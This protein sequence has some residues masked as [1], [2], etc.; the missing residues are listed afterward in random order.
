M[1]ITRWLGRAQVRA[2][3][4]TVTLSGTIVANDSFTV[5]IGGQAPVVILATNTVA[6]DVLT[7]VYNALIASR[8][9]EV[10]E[11]TWTAPS[12]GSMTYTGPT[13][14][15]AP[16]TITVATSGAATFATATTTS[17]TGPN[18]FDNT[19]NWSGAAVPTPGTDT[20]VFSNN[21][22]GMLYNISQTSTS[23]GYTVQ[24]DASTCTSQIGLSENNNSGYKE[25]RN[26]YLT[27]TGGTLT[28]IGGAN[29]GPN[30]INVDFNAT[31]AT[32]SI[33]STGQGIQR[34][35]VRVRNMANTSTLTMVSGSL[36][37]GSNASDGNSFFASA[38]ISGGTI[39]FGPKGC[40][41]DSLTQTGGTITYDGRNINS[42]VFCGTSFSKINGTFV[43][44]GTAYVGCDVTN[45]NGAIVWLSTGSSSTKQITLTGG[46]FDISLATSALSFA[47]LNLYS[48]AGYND[49]NGF[50]AYSGGI[51]LVQ[52]GVEDL[53]TFKVGKNRTLTY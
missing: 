29:P 14:D 43:V 44:I 32:V 17:P 8:F 20:L 47:K 42:A 16:V 23:G 41:K 40:L 25:Y 36:G 7:Q 24:Y 50:G 39:N 6:N 19:A 38:T 13:T 10:R 2:Q 46:S 9:P 52:C 5:T 30:L 15:G 18:F 4:G 31:A 28:I 22:V 33:Q 34:E 21:N 27:M 48:G 12:A 53:S 35:C 3:V 49:P 26:Q 1:A 45:R 37:V 11:I 51:A